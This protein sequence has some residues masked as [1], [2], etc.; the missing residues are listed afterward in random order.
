MATATLLNYSK[1]L[2]FNFKFMTKHNF[3][4]FQGST[5]QQKRQMNGMHSR[6]MQKMDIMKFTY[7]H[8]RRPHLKSCL[9][10]HHKLSF[11]TLI[12]FLWHW[13]CTTFLNILEFFQFFLLHFISVYPSFQNNVDDRSNEVHI[14]P[15]NRITPL[16]FGKSYH[17]SHSYGIGLVQDS[18]IDYIISYSDLTL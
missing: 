8:L 1:L 4:E 18:L 15:L 7:H 10:I 2:Y 9:S 14:L 3:F 17:L 12:S 6:I 11:F 16:L 5:T 13:I